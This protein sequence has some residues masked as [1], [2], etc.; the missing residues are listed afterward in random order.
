MV[1]DATAKKRLFPAGR[2]RTI[3]NIGYTVA[4]L[5]IER[6]S[7][8]RYESEVTRRILKPLALHGT[9]FPGTDPASTARTT[10]AISG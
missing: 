8:H 2:G 7:G 4:G 9:S 5:L 6:V 1:A 3:S 10:T